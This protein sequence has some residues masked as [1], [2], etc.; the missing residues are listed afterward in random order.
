LLAAVVLANAPLGLFLQVTFMLLMRT[1]APIAELVQIL[2]LQVLLVRN[3][4]ETPKKQLLAALCSPSDTEIMQVSEEVAVSD[5]ILIF[6]SV[7]HSHSIVKTYF[8]NRI[9]S[10]FGLSN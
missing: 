1:N 4:R 6:Q 5:K 3:N 10:R 2:A 9:S 7:F 8:Q